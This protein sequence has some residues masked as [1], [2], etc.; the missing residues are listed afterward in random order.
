MVQPS[1]MI[2]DLQWAMIN[3]LSEPYLALRTCF[4]TSSRTATATSV[5]VASKD[6]PLTVDTP[7]CQSHTSN[8]FRSNLEATNLRNFWGWGLSQ[9]A[10][11]KVFFIITILRGKVQNN[12]FFP[13]INPVFK[14]SFELLSGLPKMRLKFVLLMCLESRLKGCWIFDHL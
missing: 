12:F 13:I 5:P 8:L 7:C 6:Q 4:V 9:V 1:L 10:C 11:K 3:H 2:C 14:L